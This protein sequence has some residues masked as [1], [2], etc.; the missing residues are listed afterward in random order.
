MSGRLVIGDSAHSRIAFLILIL[1]QASVLIG[2]QLLTSTSLL[3]AQENRTSAVPSVFSVLEGAWEGR[4]ELLGRSAVFQM[5]WEIMSAGFIRL[6]FS[7]SWVTEDGNTTPVLSSHAVYYLRDS[8][9]VGVWL[10]DRPQRIN[11]EASVTDSSIVTQWTAKAESGR[12]E[13]LIRSPD[14]VVVHDFVYVNGAERPFAEA[15]YRRRAASP[16][17]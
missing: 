17:G 3:A 15:T 4:G 9:T 13:Y 10:D 7:N 8:S 14:S 1:L 12:T 5:R 2:A 6:T 11:L 16:G